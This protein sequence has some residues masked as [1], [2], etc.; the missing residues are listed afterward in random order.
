MPT[1]ISNLLQYE[2]TDAEGTE[3]TFFLKHFKRLHLNKNVLILHIYL[4]YSTVECLILITACLIHYMAKL[5]WTPDYH[6]N[7]WVF[8]K[9][10]WKQTI[11]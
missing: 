9:Q 2:S 7:M 5:M 1:L 10:S 3:A 6:G 8:P 4:Y 11:V